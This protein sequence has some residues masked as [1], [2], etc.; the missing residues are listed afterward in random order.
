V[1]PSFGKRD[2][3]VD[4]G[5][6]GAL[7][8]VLFVDGDHGDYVEA[9]RI[10]GYRVEVAATALL[11]LE[12]ASSVRPDALIVPLA[13]PDMSGAELADRIGAGPARTLAVVVLTRAGRGSA[14]EDGVAAAGAAF[15]RL[16]CAPSD[17]VTM[18]ARQLAGRRRLNP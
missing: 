12:R 8:H 3:V 11:A 2:D 14:H 1:S 10:A 18:V 16:P 7:A 17:L 9:L 6:I 15:C 4:D 13:M 5:Q